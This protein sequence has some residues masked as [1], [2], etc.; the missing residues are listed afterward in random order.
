MFNKNN[1]LN[2]DL[3]KRIIIRNVELNKKVYKLFYCFNKNNKYQFMKHY[4]FYYFY[5]FSSFSKLQK[6]C[7]ISNRS[8]SYSFF[9]LSRIKLREFASNGLLYNIK[10]ASW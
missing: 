2:I 10:K 6:R 4:L 8:K 3:K 9:K 5:F 1:K 7:L